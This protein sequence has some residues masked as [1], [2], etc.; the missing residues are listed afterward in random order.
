MQKVAEIL[1]RAATKLIGSRNQR[2]L[3]SMQ[4]LVARLNE[5]E[6]QTIRLSDLQLRKKTEEFRKRLADGETVDDLLCEAFAVMREACRRVVLT[7]SEDNPQPMR[8]FDV[9]LI[10]GV[11][12]HRGMIAEMATGEGKTLVATLA[13]YLNGLEA[14]GVHIVTTND[15]LARRD[16]DW[17]RPAFELLGMRVGVIQHDMSPAER[18]DAYACDVT[19]G[20]NDELGFDY[21]RNNMAVRVDDQAQGRLHYAIIDEVDSILIDEARTPLII[22]GPTEEFTDKYYLA[23]KAARSLKGIDKT[24]FDE[25]VRM[26]EEKEALD[27]ECDFVYSEKDNTAHLTER[28]VQRAQKI[29]GVD[30]FYTGANM[31]WP[32]RITQ[33]LRAHYLQRRDRDYV[34]KDRKVVIVDE[35]T[36]RLMPGRRWSDGLHQGIE[37]KEN[38]RIERETQ[39]M[40]T[41]TY[42]NFFRLYNKLAG[43]T[44][45]ALTEGAEFDK[46]YGLE[47]MVLPTNKPLRRTQHRDVVYRTEQEKFAAIEEEI[48]EIHEEG[49]PLLVGTVSIENSER[50]SRQL[51]RRGIKHE[52]LNAKHHEREAAIIAK[53]GE[54]GNVTIAT[55]MAGRGVDI[56]LGPEVAEMGGL[57]VLGT[58]R[59]EARRIDNQLRGR[60]GRQGDPGASRFFLSLEDDLMRLFASDWVSAMLRKLGME[61]GVAIENRIV[62]RAIERAQKK[63][64]EHNFDS[65]KRVLDY[66]EVMDEQRRVI[67]EMRQRAL[68][69]KDLAGMVRETLEA[70]AA[71]AVAGY[72]S[73][74]NRPDEW[75]RDG[76]GDWLQR[77]FG[78]GID[79]AL[80]GGKSADAIEEEV[81]GEVL[82]AYEKRRE[83]LGEE[84]AGRIEQ[85]LLLRAID[86]KWKDHLYAMDSL[87]QGIGLRGYAQ[88][89]PLIEYKREAFEL[90]EEMVASVRDEV[91]E[92]IFKLRL[93]AEDV[94]SYRGVMRV[95][96][97]VHEEYAAMQRMQQ[98]AVESSKAAEGRVAQIKVG[99]KVGRNDPCPC[100]SGKK[101]KK[102]C[103]RS[104]A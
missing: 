37:A 21:L 6:P 58:E 16:R 41:I 52:V 17:M 38:L 75:D 2:V 72:L 27:Q 12:L 9:Q 11:V 24:K 55:N 46:I 15:Y 22:T 95:A 30:D 65:R 81:V 91:T 90:F 92:L 19:Y 48:V 25:R 1:G 36:G 86:T 73:P 3:E 99:T 93:E 100:G 43:M 101:F 56:V 42:Q 67:Y 70:S 66:D 71:D 80:L 35:F 103:G 14:K 88:R 68:E 83:V 76:L 39:T 5:L 32:H 51:K 89:D 7:P 69:G 20:R 78:V 13:A 96:K 45:T 33:A 97:E 59:H 8:Q 102:C 26:G 50:L 87:K 28:G 104:R 18:R 34:V 60:A 47:V 85:F 98:A 77:N 84:A 82:K 40:A 62:S 79:A 23:D 63:V 57:Y 29:L 94:D 31:D 74:A 44:G 53:A 54:R 10:G 49:R 64:E 61:D 4:P